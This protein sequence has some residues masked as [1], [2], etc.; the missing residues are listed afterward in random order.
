LTRHA[1]L[2]RSGDLWTETARNGARSLG[3]EDAGTIE[4]D[5]AHPRL[6]GVPREDLARAIATCGSADM[7]VA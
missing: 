5:L 6:A 2:A 3:I 4:V 1:L 7:V